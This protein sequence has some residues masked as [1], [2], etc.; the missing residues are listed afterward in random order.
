MGPIVRA[1]PHHA[2]APATESS[3]TPAHNAREAT[4]CEKCEVMNET[5]ARYRRLRD[6]I[7]DKQVLEAATRLVAELEAKKLT[8]HPDQ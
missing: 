2:L 6:Q 4:M 7:N 5:I 3:C 1:S 8:L